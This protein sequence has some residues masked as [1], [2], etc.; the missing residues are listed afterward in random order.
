M[1]LF[2]CGWMK[3][4]YRL[5]L[6]TIMTTRF[7]KIMTNVN[8][9]MKTACRTSVTAKFEKK[10][11]AFKFSQLLFLNNGATKTVTLLS[12]TLLFIFNSKKNKI[13]LIFTFHNNLNIISIYFNNFQL[14]VKNRKKHIHKRK[15]F[16]LSYEFL[17]H[18]T[19]IVMFVE[20]LMIF[21]YE[22]HTEMLLHFSHENLFIIFIFFIFFHS[23]CC[24]KLYFWRLF[25]SR[26]REF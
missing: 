21:L 7:A 20:F 14:K 25:W 12:I 2:T 17:W 16:I 8:V 9:V 22:W 19:L 11:D 5:Q 15:Y 10:L 18:N 3:D 23:E 13:L 26:S 6:I 4:S 24:M 1:N